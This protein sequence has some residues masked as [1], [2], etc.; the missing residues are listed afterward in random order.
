VVQDNE[1][2]APTHGAPAPRLRAPEAPRA[3]AGHHD[4][5]HPRGHR[6]RADP[7]RRR[8]GHAGLPG[9]LSA[10]AN[11]PG[12]DARREQPG[13][14]GPASD[15]GVGIPTTGRGA[16]PADP[17]PPRSQRGTGDFPDALVHVY[18][19]EYRAATR[20]RGLPRVAYDPGQWSRG[21]RWRVHEA[22]EPGAWFGF[23]AIEIYEIGS[24]TVFTIP[25]VGD[26]PGHAG[27]AI[28]TERGWLLHCG[29]AF[30]PVALPPS[31][32]IGW[33][34]PRAAR[35]PPGSAGWPATSLEKSGSSDHISRSG[36]SAPGSR[37]APVV[38]SYN[39]SCK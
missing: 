4:P 33:C 31:C 6:Q 27:V 24:A 16:H 26:S 20:P 36:R 28:R 7:R 10:G 2:P 29:S 12:P 22:V 8:H 15:R 37:P 19:P 13:A 34:R 25:L 35:T 11:L 3:A 38:C 1:A 30:P 14:H 5:L 17:P 23:D 32:L 21:P 9:A 18:G 39:C